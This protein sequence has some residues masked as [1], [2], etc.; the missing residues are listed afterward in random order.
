MIEAGEEV[1]EALWRMPLGPEYERAIKSQAADLI[2]STGKTAA[3]ASV[4][5]QFL[6]HFVGK[7]AW[8]HLDVAGVMWSKEDR[9]TVPK[10]ATAFGVRLLDRL[11]A[12]HYEG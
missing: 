4:A 9:P 8:A 3:G 11:I 6:Q 10:G 1:G 7:T 5:A 2:N 12:Q